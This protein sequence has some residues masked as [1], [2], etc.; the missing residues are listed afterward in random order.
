MGGL[1]PRDHGRP[2]C[3]DHLIMKAVS[4]RQ[5]SAAAEALQAKQGKVSMRRLRGSSRQMYKG[6]SEQQLAEVASTDRSSL[7]VRKTF[8]V[9]SRD[10]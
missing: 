2:S 8:R 5:Q 4:Q 6:M 9:L 1:G 7:P 10:N 3:K